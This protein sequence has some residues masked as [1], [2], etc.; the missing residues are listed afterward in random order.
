MTNAIRITDPE[1]GASARIAPALGLNCFEF[2]AVLSGETISVIDSPADVL[3]GNA[4]PSSYG[5]PL[6][7]PFPNRIRGG[8]YTWDGVDYEIPLLDGAPNAIHGFCLDRPWRVIQ[9]SQNTVTG[10]FQLSVDAPDRLQSWPADFIL[11]VRYRVA[12]NRLE[13]QF[14]ITNPDSRPLP[15]GLG[16]HAYFRLPFSAKSR[17]E[18]CVASVSVSEEW[19]LEEFLPTGRRL[20]VENR[21]PLRTGARFGTVQPDNVYTGWQSDGG[22]VR[23]ALLDEQAGIELTQVCDA[24]YFRE[25]VAYVPPGRD[26]ICLE[27]YTCVTDAINL[28]ARDLNT[29]W[30]VLPPG[31][32]VQTWCALQVNQVIV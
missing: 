31:G 6:L 27:P 18:D 14:R 25:M 16:T 10:Q 9:Q 19:E 1:S 28:Q 29:G 7:F 17:P 11:D 15:W 20:P 26:S 24:E 30:Q 21:A 4:R 2:Q 13:C 3:K 32:V 5:I 23:T 8:R 12:E 22:T